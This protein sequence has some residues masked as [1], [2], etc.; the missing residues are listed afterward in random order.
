MTMAKKHLLLIASL[1]LAIAVTLG[2]LAMLPPSSGVTKGNLDRIQMGMTKSEVEQIFGKKGKPYLWT[3]EET[4]LQWDADDGS[5]AVIEL[6]D[7]G[8]VVHKAWLQS[9]G[10]FTAKIR[11]WLRLP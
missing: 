8:V 5:C 10:A 4:P 3:G 7:D 9:S 11:R 2:V 6:S 1:P